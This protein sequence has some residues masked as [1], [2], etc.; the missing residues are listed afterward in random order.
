MKS[1][2]RKYDAKK[3]FKILKVK[4]SKKRKFNE[5]VELL[6]KLKLN[7]KIKKHEFLKNLKKF[8][9]LKNEKRKL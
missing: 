7:D 3:F 8:L 2:K 5:T 9:S 4:T 6:D 1:L